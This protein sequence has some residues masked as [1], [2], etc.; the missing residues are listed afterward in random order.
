MGNG[1]DYGLLGMRMDRRKVKEF[2]RMG[3]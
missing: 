3:N 2:S 1:M